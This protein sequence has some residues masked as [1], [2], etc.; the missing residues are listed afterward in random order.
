MPQR[1]VA[2][3]FTFEQQRVE[4]NELAADFW[5]QKGVTDTAAGTYL[6][7][8][9]SNAFT[10][11]TLNVPNA[12]TIA[13][14]A[15]AGTVTINA[16]LQV[17]GTTTTLNSTTLEIAD[18]N[19]VLAK[20]SANDAAADGAGLTV[21][22]STDKTFNFV[23]ADD[24]FV[25]SIGLKAVGNITGAAISGTTGTFSGNVNTGPV[26]T[27]QGT[28]GISANLYLIADDG[29]DNGDGW[30]INSNQDDNDLTISNN[31]SGSYVDKLTILKT[32]EVGI[33][34]TPTAG[35]TLALAGNMQFTVANP[36]LEFNNGGPRLWS[37]AANTLTIHTGGG[38]GS[39]SNE[40][41]RITSAGKVVI[42]DT[43]SDSL[44]GVYRDSHQVA[45]FTNTNANATGAELT[46][47]KDSASPA[48]G[49]SLGLI[50]FTGDN[51]ANE[52]TL[53]SYIQ[54]KSVDVSDGSEDG[55]IGFFTRGGGTLGERIQIHSDGQVTIGDD[56]PGAGGWDG[57]L[58][59]ANTTGGRISVGD[60]GS[61]ERFDI[62]ANGDINL[63]SFLDGDHINFHTTDSTS[64]AD[65]MRIQSNGNVLVGINPTTSSSGSH[66]GNVPF[67]INGAAKNAITLMLGDSNDGTATLGQN[68]Y[69]T[70]IRF[71]GADVA[72]GDI[73]YYPNGDG[74]NGSFR[75]TR[76]GSTVATNGN[77]TIGCGAINA[78]GT[79][80]PINDDSYD[81]GTSTLR[82]RNVY[83]ADLQMNNTG[84]GGNEVDGSEGHWTMQEGS[85]DLFLI[86][87]NTGKKYKFNLTEVS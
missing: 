77:A 64:T 3:N 2:S 47:R 76:N 11:G 13:S 31:E 53:Y 44:F 28:E 9:G 49:D 8:D 73:S 79:I 39:T 35:S 69:S 29:D 71:N 37:P 16:N 62:A 32:G 12:F 51:D 60:T 58:V 75:F 5:T 36:Q 74:A 83:T 21:D 30:R 55:N 50:N 26:F 25:S 54:A 52:K 7:K 63:Y 19:I 23:D 14:N 45:E 56:H 38:F 66:E 70:D 87:R 1:N 24:A 17:Q 18:K 48:D 6:L 81:L 10:G 67:C 43:N 57:N 84:T 61:G 34:V 65:R 20:G 78:Q 59:V 46:L 80:K 4:I 22:S 68:E 86:N 42:G 72:W 15:G 82:W 40:K 33:G 41:M 27:V 85:D